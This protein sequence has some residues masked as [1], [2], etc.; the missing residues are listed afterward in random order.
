MLENGV[1]R[2]LDFGCARDS[3]NGDATLTIALKHGYAPVEQYQNKGQG[4]WSDVYALCATIYFCL[5]GRKPPQSM[6]RLV[7]DELVPPRKLG[8]DDHTA[9]KGTFA[10]YGSAPKT[11]FLFCDRTVYGTL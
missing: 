11:A 2:L 7:G 8:V 6:D 5:T 10:W 1:V 3:E 9:G 4:P